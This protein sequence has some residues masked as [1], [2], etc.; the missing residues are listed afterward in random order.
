LEIRWCLAAPALAVVFC[1]GAAAAEIEVSHSETGAL[2]LRT[3]GRSRSVATSWPSRRP[4]AELVGLIERYARLRDLKPELVHAVIAA[5]SAYDPRALSR[6]GA[7]GLMQ[8]MP[9]T[10][11]ELGVREPYDPEENIGGGTLYLRRLLDRFGELELALAAYN[12]GPTAVER[13]GD[14]P[15]YAETRT[16]VRRVLSL[17]DGD[18]WRGAVSVAVAPAAAQRPAVGTRPVK[19]ARDP[20]GRIVIS[21]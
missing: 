6:K 14:V 10:A 21:Q 18:G 12:A 7:Q 9:E 20:A 1:A 2:V 15:P 11:R 16:Y 19:V 4:S 3:V 13:H 17:Y 5:E 8:L